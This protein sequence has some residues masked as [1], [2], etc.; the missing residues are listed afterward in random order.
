M[1]KDLGNV[2]ETKVY[3]VVVIGAGA[4]GMTASLYT[5][6]AGLDT[7]MLERGVEGGQ[8]LNTDTVENYTGSGIIKGYELAE[9]M[10]ED[11][12]RFGAVSVFGEVTGITVDKDTNL[13]TVHTTTK[14]YLAKA[15]II[16][17]GTTNKKLGIE[18]EQELLGRGVSYCAVCDGA[19]FRN[20]ELV[21]IGGGDSAVEEGLYLTQ[22]A[23]KVTL[24]HRR[25]EL[26]AQKILQDR[27]LSH[28]KT[29]VIWDANV[30]SIKG[31]NGVE[32]V[33]VYNN[34]TGEEY[35]YSTD[36]TFIYVGLIPNTEPFEELGI[37]DESGF[38]PTDH[39][40]QTSI[41]GVYA[42][43]DVRDTPLR[44]IS[45]AVSDGAIA[46]NEVFNYIQN[47]F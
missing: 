46:G 41:S 6:R 37:L 17:T 18:G 35:E 22:F 31:K 40:M 43:G 10:K 27:F 28:P 5:S 23:D 1:A 15:V 44:Q 29:D 13:K 34:K 42:T 26:R 21:V 25:D 30:T 14:D 38:I 20:R 39:L 24:I 16:G 8:L 45:T 36:G 7:L 2:K 19:F 47:N 32:G 3:D 33:R 9:K 12:L 11:A 4:S